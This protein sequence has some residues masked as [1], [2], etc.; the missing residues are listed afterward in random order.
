MRGIR[1]ILLVALVVLV[2]GGA[3]VWYFLLRDT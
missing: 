2:M 3:G 1:R